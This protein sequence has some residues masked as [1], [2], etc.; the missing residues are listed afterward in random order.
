MK[1]KAESDIDT[2]ASKRSAPEFKLHV[3]GI[4]VDELTNA[5]LPFVGW[6]DGSSIVAEYAR[7]PTLR[8]NSNEPHFGGFYIELKWRDQVGKITQELE[9]RIA[10]A[11]G[12]CLPP[13]E[14]STYDV[15]PSPTTLFGF[16]V[17]DYETDGSSSER[18]I[19]GLW[20]SKSDEWVSS[21][22]R[23]AWQLCGTFIGEWATDI[24]VSALTKPVF[25]REWVHWVGGHG[26]RRRR[27]WSVWSP[28]NYG[29]GMVVSLPSD[30]AA[31]GDAPTTWVHQSESINF[32]QPFWE[33]RRRKGCSLNITCKCGDC[34]EDCHNQCDDI[35]LY[36]PKKGK[37]ERTDHSLCKCSFVAPSSDGDDE[38]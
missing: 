7:T 36:K 11:I 24:A 18:P 16:L 35:C 1:R 33:E 14:D 28:D 19:D 30:G 31:H 22:A 4:T 5:C 8:W 32:V 37:L 20:T 10:L 23:V 12:L 15:L 34:R 38:F 21:P 26:F 2:V 3:G 25:A 27:M 29:A 6:L 13:R 9:Q 17:Y